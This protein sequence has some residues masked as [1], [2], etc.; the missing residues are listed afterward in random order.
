MFY[1]TSK[2]SEVFLTMMWVKVIY[3]RFSS[4]VILM[5]LNMRFVNVKFSI[6]H[7][8]VNIL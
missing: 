2:M 7:Y 6:T 4:C 8:V 1:E 5:I 3:K